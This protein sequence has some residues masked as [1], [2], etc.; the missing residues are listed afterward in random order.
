MADATRQ[1]AS[2]LPP[3]HAVLQLRRPPHCGAFARAQMMPA[4]CRRSPKMACQRDV[5]TQ[6][7]W[8]L[9]WRVLPCWLSLSHRQWFRFVTPLLLALR[10]NKKH[11]SQSHPSIFY[12]EAAR[13][14]KSSPTLNRLWE[15]GGCPSCWSFSSS[16][17]FVNIGTLLKNRKSRPVHLSASLTQ[18][19]T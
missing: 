14:R 7:C 5:V 15:S 17:D 16:N 6:Q 13:W 3:Y 12:T 1:L 11:P 10:C 18:S 2:R 8:C 19:L 4:L 9:V